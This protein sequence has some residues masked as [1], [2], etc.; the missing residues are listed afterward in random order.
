[1]SVTKSPHSMVRTRAPHPDTLLHV[2]CPLTRP[3]LR[4]ERE[5]RV[6]VLLVLCDHKRV[7]PSW[8]QPGRVPSAVV[9]L[10]SLL[11]NVP[12]LRRVGT[13]VIR[14]TPSHLNGA[15]VAFFNLC[16]LSELVSLFCCVGIKACP[17]T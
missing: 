8:S 4:M 6:T 14:G 2:L 13:Y 7:V 11:T 15:E 3:E 16:V 17:D 10:T 5:G 12:H 9:S 1:M